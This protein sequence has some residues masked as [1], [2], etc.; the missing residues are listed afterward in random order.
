MSTT[1]KEG[2][3]LYTF[4]WIYFDKWAMFGHGNSTFCLQYCFV[5]SVTVYAIQ[6]RYHVDNHGEGERRAFIHI[7]CCPYF[8]RTN[9]GFN[10]MGLNLGMDPGNISGTMIRM[11]AEE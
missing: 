4:Y 10:Q 5:E 2:R 6:P 7:I 11:L 9:Q 1:Q 3:G 8:A